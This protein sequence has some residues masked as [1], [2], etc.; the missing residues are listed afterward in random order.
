[1]RRFAGVGGGGGGRRR[2][3]AALAA[4]AAT[5]AGVAGCEPWRCD[6]DSHGACVEFVT[7]PADL[8]DAKARVDRILDLEL[9]YWNLHS[10][11]GWRIQYRDSP[12]YVCYFS[13]ENEGCTD[14]LNQTLSVRVPPDSE[15]C[16]EAAELLHELGH[17]ELGDPMHA[18][19]R[20]DGVDGE[21]AAMVWDRPDAAEP[22]VRR[23]GGIRSGMWP[24]NRNSL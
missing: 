5:A 3:L 16:F 6:F 12:E 23:Y 4:L 14:Y 20:W 8:A 10:L 24:V 18:S 11:S 21:F 9:P 13:S 22:C 1:M 2:S 15:G 19:S 17:Y 7:D